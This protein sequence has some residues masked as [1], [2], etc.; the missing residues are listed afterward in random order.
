MTRFIF[1]GPPFGPR[2]TGL[3]TG[4]ATRILTAPAA[5][6]GQRPGVIRPRA[7]RL[8]WELEEGKLGPPGPRRRTSRTRAAAGVRGGP[9]GSRRP[10]ALSS[11]PPPTL[12]KSR[13]AAPP[14]SSSRIRPRF[15]RSQ[16][17][18]GGSGP[19]PPLRACCCG[20]PAHS[21]CPRKATAV[22]GEG[23]GLRVGAA[24]CP[25]SLHWSVAPATGRW[26]DRGGKFCQ[27]RDQ[28]LASP[29]KQSWGGRSLRQNLPLLL[30]P[31]KSL[32]LASRNTRRE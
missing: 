14:G 1:Q 13:S 30:P 4:K 22:P 2:A 19:G 15:F 28:D 32:L 11:T 29:Q 8:I 31:E 21:Q 16:T 6:I 17:S 20:R 25:R 12:A 3:G 23:R 9:V 10:L 24:G 5:Y 26:V 18:F 27:R 7:R